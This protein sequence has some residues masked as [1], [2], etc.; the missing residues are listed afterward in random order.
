MSMIGEDNLRSIFWTKKHLL[1][2]AHM[3]NEVSNYARV[4]ADI[5]PEYQV[6]SEQLESDARTLRAIINRL[7]ALEQWEDKR[8][9]RK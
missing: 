8:R 7:S 4:F 9:E 1:Q 5:E 2:S 6:V 3:L